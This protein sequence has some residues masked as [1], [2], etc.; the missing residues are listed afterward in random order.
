MSEA[1]DKVWVVVSSKGRDGEPKLAAFTSRPHIADTLSMPV[2]EYELSPVVPPS[3]VGY[4]TRVIDDMKEWATT[5]TR[6]DQLIAKCA[7]E[8][9]ALR[10][11][12]DAHSRVV[13]AVAKDREETKAELEKIREEIAKS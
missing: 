5:H 1:P 6:Q 4:L 12:N 9:A 2:Y 11:A 13:R 3:T 7:Q 10:Q 8:I